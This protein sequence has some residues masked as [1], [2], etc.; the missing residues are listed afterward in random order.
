MLACSSGGIAPSADDGPLGSGGQGQ[1]PGTFG[2]GGEPGEAGSGGGTWSGSGGTSGGS[3]SGSGELPT[4]GAG[5]GGEG[6]GTGGTAGSDSGLPAF[7]I[8]ADITITLEDE[9][10]GATY[11]DAGV[12]KPL[13]QVLQEHGFNA[14][15]IDTFVNPSAAGGYA[16]AKEQ[17]FRSLAQTITLAKRVKA[18]DMTFLLDLHMSDTWTNPGAQGM[19]AAWVGMNLGQLEVAVHDYVHDTVTALIS[20]GARPDLIQLGNEITNGFLWEL[21]RIN[22]NDFSGFTTLLKAGTSAIRD[23]DPKILVMLHIEKCNNLA[24]SRWWLNGVIDAGVQF[25]VLGQSCYA[26]AVIDGSEHHPG[27]QGTP[28]EWKATFTA[29]ASEF[30]QLKFAIAEYSAEPRAAGDVLFDL[31]QGR[32]IGTF[33]W[34]PTRFY[35]THPNVPLFET[36]S[37]WNDYV[38]IPERMAVYEKMASDYGLTD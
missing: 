12:T 16:E 17:P 11:R 36:D 6:I 21:G 23:I 14:I 37:A 3:D 5:T 35:E 34:D 13:E 7:L 4:G 9:Y 19:P 33:N 32:G 8:G 31:P 15:R 26:A 18:R 28:S 25:D 10:W 20:A 22:S 1:R 29:L 27:Y 24:T 30:P 38:S 2:S